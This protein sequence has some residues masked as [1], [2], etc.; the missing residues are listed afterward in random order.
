MAT[1]DELLDAINT[2]I[3]ELQTAQQTVVSGV[4]R[5]EAVAAALEPQIKSATDA[6]T[7]TEQGLYYCTNC[8]TALHY[9]VAGTELVNVKKSGNSLY[10]IAG[11]MSATSFNFRASNDNGNSWTAW[12][13]MVLTSGNQTINGTKTF[14]NLPVVPTTTPTAD[15]QVACKKYVDDQLSSN[16]VT[17]IKGNAENTYRNGNVNLTPANIGALASTGGTLTGVLYADGNIHIRNKTLTISHQDYVKGND[18]DDNITTSIPFHDSQNIYESSYRLGAITNTVY[19]TKNSATFLSAYANVEDS[20]DAASLGVIMSPNGVSYAYAP[21]PSS[22]SDSSNKIA[23]TE[24]VDNFLNSNLTVEGNKIFT[25]I[26][27]VSNDRPQI[28]LINKSLTKGANPTSDNLY[29]LEFLD[30]NGI[31]TKNRLGLLQS[32]VRTSGDVEIILRAYKN[33]ANSSASTSISLIYSASGSNY[34]ETPSVRPNSDNAHSLGVATR[35]FT[36]VFAATATINTSDERVKTSISNFPDEV[37]DAWAE[38]NW[39]QFQF[40]DA[41]AEK[42]SNARIH[43]GTLAQWI[44]EIFQRRNLDATR[45]GLLCHDEWEAEDWDEIVVDKRAVTESV[46]VIDKEAVY[47]SDGLEITPAITHYEERIIEPEESHIVHHH[48]DAGDLYSLRY[49]EC[50]AVEAA[51][52]RRRANRMEARLAAI[53]AKLGL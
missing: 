41:V 9:P 10:Q 15:G 29:Y 44:L 12:I 22:A 3:S 42:G 30:T 16:A 4:A 2:A 31:A 52:Q 17:G 11:D 28:S 48:V 21:T 47:N 51:Y 8:T 49:E 40:K 24:W 20:L 19:T 13:G 25:D 35:R 18:L 26:L 23:T 50:F 53:E 37:L 5:V 32:A 33:E 45:Y 34:L 1:S 14:K 46:K 6:N 27:S 43:S 36:Q 38:V 39:Q 7:L